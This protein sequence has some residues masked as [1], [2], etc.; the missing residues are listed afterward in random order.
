MRKGKENLNQHQTI[1]YTQG[2]QF[3]L[4]S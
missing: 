1:K 2:K 4:H 3:F